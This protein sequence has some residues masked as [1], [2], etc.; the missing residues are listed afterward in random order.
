MNAEKRK[1]LRKEAA[2]GVK[3]AVHSHNTMVM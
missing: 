1:D 3:A 2:A